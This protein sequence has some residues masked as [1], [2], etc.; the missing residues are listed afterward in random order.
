[1]NAIS[2]RL[3]GLGKSITL[4]HLRWPYPIKEVIEHEDVMEVLDSKGTA[5]IALD[6]IRLSDLSPGEP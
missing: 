2:F 1:V 5:V 6:D 3:K 4:G